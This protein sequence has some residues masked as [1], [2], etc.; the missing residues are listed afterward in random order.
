MKLAT[1]QDYSFKGDG[2]MAQSSLGPGLMEQQGIVGLTDQ[3]M[4]GTNT[5]GDHRQGWPIC[6][7]KL[8][9]PLK[10]GHLLLARQ[11]RFSFPDHYRAFGD[12]VGL[13]KRTTRP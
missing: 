7:W 13:A 11:A 12:R 4:S 8:C 1:L 10:D 9:L 5:N 6:R 3:S 2:T